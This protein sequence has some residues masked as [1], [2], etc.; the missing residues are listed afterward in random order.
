MVPSFVALKKSNTG[1]ADD[2][3]SSLNRDVL[4]N[5]LGSVFLE[6]ASRV[7]H[8]FR[9]IVSETPCHEALVTLWKQ[10]EARRIIRKFLSAI[11]DNT[12]ASVTASAFDAFDRGHQQLVATLVWCLHNHHKLSVVAR[13]AGGERKP[14]VQLPA[15]LQH[16]AEEAAQMAQPADGTLS[17]PLGYSLELPLFADVEY[18][19]LHDDVCSRLVELKLSGIGQNITIPTAVLA[20]PLPALRM[21][22][23]FNCR[24][25][26]DFGAG[27]VRVISGSTTLETLYIGSTR[28]FDDSGATALARELKDNVV[29]TDLYL[30]WNGIRAAGAAALADALKVNRVLKDLRLIGNTVGTKG[31]EALADALKVNVGL[32]NLELTVNGIG[33][34]GATALAEALKVNGALKTLN[35]Q[36]NLISRERRGALRAAAA[37]HPALEVLLLSFVPHK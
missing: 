33:D 10:P 4:R 14:T 30:G 12:P 28:D 6:P 15:S 2:L 18:A 35:L 7:S 20:K 36:G 31:A 37:A 25:E 16:V 3:L 13:L 29:L 34:D 24:V 23:I 27:L 21:L 19:P 9:W 26:P 22:R 17:V 5:I 32:R 11:E 8:L 1:L